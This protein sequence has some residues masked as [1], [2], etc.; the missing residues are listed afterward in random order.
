MHNFIQIIHSI[1]PKNDSMSLI[2]HNTKLLAW[3]QHYNIP[4]HLTLCRLIPPC[5]I[6]LHCEGMLIKSAK[7]FVLTKP[8]IILEWIV[9]DFQLAEFLCFISLCVQN[10]STNPYISVTV[11]L[12]AIFSYKIHIILRKKNWN[13]VKMTVFT[14]SS[15]ILFSMEN[16]KIFGKIIYTS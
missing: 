4:M 6:K 1:R 13:V 8:M 15:Q 5:I 9:L 10:I 14:T 12:R 16:K 3:T 7:S 2:G 11:F